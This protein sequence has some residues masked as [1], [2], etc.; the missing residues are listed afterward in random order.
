VTR[1]KA[2]IIMAIVVAI[3]L[4]LDVALTVWYIDARHDRSTT[5]TTASAVVPAE[6]LF[7]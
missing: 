6:V 4:A 7:G 5:T 2:I 1:R 3:L